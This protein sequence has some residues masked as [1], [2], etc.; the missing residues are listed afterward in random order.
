MM[1]KRIA[2]RR[3]RKRPEKRIRRVLGGRGGGALFEGPI[4]ERPPAAAAA[5]SPISREPNSGSGLG[6]VLCNA[7][8]ARIN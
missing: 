8:D 1:K 7:R 2:V 6:L 5:T 3:A 4:N